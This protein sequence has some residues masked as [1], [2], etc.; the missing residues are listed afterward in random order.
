MAFVYSCCFWFSLRLGGIL[1]GIFSIFQA[2]LILI[3]CGL[4][5][6]HTQQVIDEIKRWS[7]SLN[8]QSSTNYIEQFII[9]IIEEPDKCITICTTL[10][11]IYIVICL[12]FIY[13][14][15]SCNNIWMVTYTLVELVRLIMLSALIATC[16]LLLK[17]NTMDIGLLIGASVTSGFFLL[18][19]FY[20]WI[21]AANLPILIN[22]MERDEQN[23]KIN[24]LQKLI[25]INN[26]STHL[27][28]LDDIPYHVDI[29]SIPAREL[30][31]SRT[32]YPHRFQ[33]SG[34]FDS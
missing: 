10:L 7:T 2:L 23:E 21:C 27:G 26:R 14:A 1:I 24:K 34:S 22:E 4:V 30:F 31:V 17:Q 18:G 28:G 16:L 19:M 6:A 20:L 3:I 5:H 13:G 12:A 32:K 15:Y 25:E 9:Y 8:L 29:P 11:C 33:N